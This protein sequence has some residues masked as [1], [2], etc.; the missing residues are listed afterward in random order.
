MRRKTLFLTAGLFA[1]FLGAY[2]YLHR[3][4]STVAL[5][6]LHSRN[7]LQF[8]HGYIY[9]RW[10]EPYL[11]II[12][13]VLENPTTVPKSVYDSCGN[14]LLET[15]H[16]KVVPINEARRLVRIEEDISLTNLEQVIPF[17]RAR[18]IVIQNPHHI[19]VVD[20]FCRRVQENP[21]QPLGVCIYIGEPL[22][23]FVVEHQ[24]EHARWVSRDEAVSILGREHRRGRFHTVWFKDAAGDRFYSICNCCNCC[25]LG[26]KTFELFDKR[27]ITSSGYSAQVD[28]DICEA[29]GECSK[30]CPFEAVSLNDKAQVDQSNCMGCGLCVDKCEQNALSLCRDLSKPK[31]LDIDNLI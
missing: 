18:D 17:E 20:C 5:E 6:K 27:A 13:R 1:G 31:P 21:C 16:S 19:A 28:D 4:D 2:L 30:I 7:P 8:L 10:P 3:K 23:G 22:S 26:M 29:C 24:P 15:Y 25:C 14:Y 9:F 11:K 12:K